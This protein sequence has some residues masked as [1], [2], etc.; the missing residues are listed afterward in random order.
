[1]MIRVVIRRGAANSGRI[2]R[3]LVGSGDTTSHPCFT[4]NLDRIEDRLKKLE[5][6]KT[7]QATQLVEEYRKFLYLL[8]TNM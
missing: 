6:I 7:S 1:M 8:C 4:I 3:T 5:E 2:I